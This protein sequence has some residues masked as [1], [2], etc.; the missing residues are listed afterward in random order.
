MVKKLFIYS[1]YVILMIILS[2]S[3]VF[4]KENK[5]LDTDN[6]FIIEGIV[7]D[8]K[9]FE[10]IINVYIKQKDSLNSV[11]STIDG[12]FKIEI[13]KEYPK[14]LIFEKEGYE[15]IELSVKKSK[16]KIKVLLSTIDVYV[17]SVPS[18]HTEVKIP[19]FP[20]LG[21]N[22]SV[23]YQIRHEV[24]SSSD[25]TTSGWGI[26]E[27]GLTCQIKLDNLL[28]KFKGFKGRIPVDIQDFPSQ[29]TF[30]LDTIQAKFGSG[31]V[32]E[33]KS[34]SMEFLLAGDLLFQRII[35][36]NK[37]SLDNKPIPYTNSVIDFGQNRIFIGLEGTLGYQL[38]KSIS[39]I[40]GAVLY[41]GLTFFEDLN[42]FPDFNLMIDI[43]VSLR[44]EII[45]GIFCNFDLENQF[46]TNFSFLNN[47]FY[48]GLSVSIDPWRMT[49]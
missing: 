41:P 6:N 24:Y 4:S 12:K 37:N 7:L 46:F 10:P 26:N 31:I 35:P 48:I 9:T 18:S 39:L 1:L 44:Y 3:I 17:P 22:F 16:E 5:E 38:T 20:I 19:N 13:R 23:L 32:N 47:V 15:P 14:V 29:P 27:I 43:P 8:N 40:G 34:Q 49:F 28:F 33:I 21:N 11:L 30:Y 2:S 36:D 42:K 25:R 45:S